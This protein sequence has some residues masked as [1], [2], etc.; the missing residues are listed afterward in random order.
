M[1]NLA[2][3]IGAFAVQLSRASSQ[4][5]PIVDGNT[6][7]TQYDPWSMLS[8]LHLSLE[9]LMYTLLA[10]SFSIFAKQAL[11]YRCAWRPWG[12]TQESI[13]RCC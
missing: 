5:L 11:L 7:Y 6:L 4:T 8:I 2:L 12:I 3:S 10:A 9:T 13:A 1:Q